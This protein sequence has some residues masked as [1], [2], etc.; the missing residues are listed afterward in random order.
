METDHTGAT[1]RKN[2]QDWGVGRVMTTGSLHAQLTG[3]SGFVT[4][5]EEQGPEWPHIDGPM[6]PALELRDIVKRWKGPGLVLDHVDLEALPGSAIH[7]SGR[8]GCGK[9][10]L[11]RIVVGLIKPN[12][13]T[14][15]AGG[16]GP[17]SA[18][19]AYQQQF[20]YVAAGDRA[21]YARMTVRH[22]MRLWARLHFI[23]RSHE[24]QAIERAMAR[25]DLDELADR[26]VDRISMGQRQRVR[27]AGCFVH[28]PAIV[29]LDEPRNSLDD[30]GIALL[31]RWLDEITRRDR[32]II[33]CSPNGEATD[34]DFTDR[35]VLEG[36]KLR[37]A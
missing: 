32:I 12:S 9:T 23:P 7:I 6:T 22:H 4:A 28:D 34:L 27:L 8:N 24:Q 20:G 31:L 11:L 15:S 17:D 25:F 10:T 19:R 37:Q 26:R 16:L 36:G 30:D 21:L 18:R 14:V 33:W 13:G 3:S 29:L 35:F 2:G 5:V 1:L